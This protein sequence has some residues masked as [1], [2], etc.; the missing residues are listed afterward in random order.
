MGEVL[1][2]K[3]RLM[4]SQDDFNKYN[5]VLTTCLYLFLNPKP[6]HALFH[7]YD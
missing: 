2:K 5:Q 7:P 1:N 3:S 4:K 6:V